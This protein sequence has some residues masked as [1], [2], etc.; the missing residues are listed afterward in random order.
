MKTQKLLAA[1]ALVLGCVV[2]Q[3][4][5]VVVVGAKS[6]V[7][8]LT[9][10]QVAQIFLGKV[11]TFP[12]GEQ[13]SPIDQPD[14]V[15]IRNEFYEKLTNKTQ[16]QV[17]AYR[18]NMVFSGKGKPPK[19]VANSQ[20]VKKALSESPSSIGYIEKAAVDGSVKVVFTQP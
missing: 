2:A 14:G 9:S 11:S 10:E 20:D 15:G 13:A 17:L 1:S 18:A 12:G 7:S 5:F 8:T 3:A 4:E 19:E 16:K 6:P